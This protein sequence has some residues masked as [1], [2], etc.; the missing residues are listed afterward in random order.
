[1]DSM[2]LELELIDLSNKSSAVAEMG[3]RATIDMGRKE[4]GLL[5]VPLFAGKLSPRLIQC[6]LGPGYFRT[7]LPSDV[8]IHPAV[9]PQ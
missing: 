2:P 6:G 7:N 1:M 4:R 9:W 8:F 5:I 3:G